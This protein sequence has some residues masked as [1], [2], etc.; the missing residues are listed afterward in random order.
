MRAR[1]S[2]SRTCTPT[3]RLLN[4]VGGASVVARYWSMDCPLPP[5]E[6]VLPKLLNWVPDLRGRA[7]SRPPVPRACYEPSVWPSSPV[8]RA[9][10]RLVPFRKVSLLFQGSIACV[11]VLTL[12]LVSVPVGQNRLLRVPLG[13]R[14]TT[15][16]VG[17]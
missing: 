8:C 6:V 13:V 3:C 14:K 11:M 17:G 10:S 4:R 16:R 15:R 1:T 12:K 5:P 7:V 9:G 2:V